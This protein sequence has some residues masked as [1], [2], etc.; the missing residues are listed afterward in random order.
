MKKVKQGLKIINR[1]WKY[2]HYLSSRSILALK[3]IWRS[4]NNFNI[5]IFPVFDPVT[6]VCSGFKLRTKVHKE[7]D[8]HRGLQV[9]IVRIHPKNIH[10]FQIL[11]QKRSKKVDINAGKLDQSLATQMIDRDNID[12]K[13]R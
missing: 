4:K 12:E 7:G 6:E 2:L 3:R 10:T 13:K 5:Q 9:H 8:W 11:V 1:T